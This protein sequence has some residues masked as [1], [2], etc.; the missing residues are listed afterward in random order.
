MYVIVRQELANKARNR[1]FELT[2]ATATQHAQ[3]QSRSVFISFRL[4]RHADAVAEQK[5]HPLFRASLVHKIDE[6][7]ASLRVALIKGLN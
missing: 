6:H 4:Q 2:A 7:S 1:C 3:I 5:V